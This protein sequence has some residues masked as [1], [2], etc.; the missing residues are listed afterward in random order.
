MYCF[1]IKCYLF[2]QDG[3]EVVSG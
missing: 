3:Q 2:S 1:Q